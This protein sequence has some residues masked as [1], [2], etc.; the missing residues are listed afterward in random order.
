MDL[1]KTTILWGSLDILSF[2]WFVGKSFARANIP[3]ISEIKQS[4]MTA[5]SFGVPSVSAIGIISTIAYFTLIISGVLL[6]TRKKHGAIL[7]YIQCPLRLVLFI[8]PSIFFITW[9]IKYIFGVPNGDSLQDIFHPSIIAWF[10]LILVSE[11]LKMITV[12]KWHKQLNRK[13]V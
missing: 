6:V 12:I 10:T 13:G 2:S 11:I 3:F 7:S 5:K 9:P 1:N 4:I 8:P